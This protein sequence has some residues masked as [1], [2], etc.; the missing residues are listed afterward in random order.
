[1]SDATFAASFGLSPLGV[2]GRSTNTSGNV[3]LAGSAL[4]PTITAE[5]RSEFY[6]LLSTL[7]N[8]GCDISATYIME[9]F[10]TL[11][12]FDAILHSDERHLFVSTSQQLITKQLK[13]LQTVRHKVKLLE[14]NATFVEELI[15][16][17]AV[18]EV[19]CGSHKAEELDDAEDGGAATATTAPDMGT[20]VAEEDAEGGEVSN[21]VS[22]TNNNEDSGNAGGEPAGAVRSSPLQQQQQRVTSSHGMR[23]ALHRPHSGSL[24]N[25]VRSTTSSAHRRRCFSFDEDLDEIIHRSNDALAALQQQ[26]QQQQEQRQEQERRGG[27]EKRGTGGDINTFTVSSSTSPFRQRHLQR[28]PPLPLTLI[29]DITPTATA[30]GLAGGTPRTASHDQQG[31]QAA[32]SAAPTAEPLVERGSSD[33]ATGASPS[34]DDKEGGS[35]IGDNSATN[36]NAGVAPAVFA[37]VQHALQNHF[38]QNVKKTLTGT[39]WTAPTS[40][41]ETAPSRDPGA[42]ECSTSPPL[43]DVNVSDSDK[44]KTSVATAPPQ[45]QPSSSAC[46]PCRPFS[47]SQLSNTSNNKNNSLYPG[48]INA[49]S[50]N[51]V[52]DFSV[53]A[54]GG[55]GGGDPYA[56]LYFSTNLD[57]VDTARVWD[58]MFWGFLDGR[59]AT[60]DLVILLSLLNNANAALA[61]LQVSEMGGKHAGSEAAPAAISSTNTAKAA[62]KPVG[63]GIGSSNRLA[64]SSMD[65]VVKSPTAPVIPTPDCGALPLMEALKR[66]GSYAELLPP[67]VLGNMSFAS[68]V[69]AAAAAGVSLPAIA[70]TAAG[71]AGTTEDSAFPRIRRDRAGELTEDEEQARAV[72]CTTD[73]PAFFPGNSAVVNMRGGEG[74]NLTYTTSNLDNAALPPPPPQQTPRQWLNLEDYARAEEAR[75]HRDF[76]AHIPAV[77][78]TLSEGLMYGDSHRGSS[79]HA[80][81]QKDEKAGSDPSSSGARR[82]RQRSTSTA[83]AAAVAAEAGGEVAG[84]PANASFLVDTADQRGVHNGAEDR[85]PWGDVTPPHAEVGDDTGKEEDEEREEAAAES[86]VFVPLHLPSEEALQLLPTF[87]PLL[88]NY[89]GAVGKLFHVAPEYARSTQA[90]HARAL[91]NA[92]A[93][94]QQRHQV[95]QQLDTPGLIDINTVSGFTSES[96]LG[97]VSVAVSTATG[98]MVP[99]SGG[100]GTARKL[101]RAATHRSS[102]TNLPELHERAHRTYSTSGDRRG[103][104]PPPVSGRNRSGG[105]DASKS[106]QINALPTATAAST[107]ATS[108]ERTDLGLLGEGSCTEL[109][110]VDV[111]LYALVTAVYVQ[112]AMPIRYQQRRQMM[113]GGAKDGAG[114]GGRSTAVEH[115][116]ALEERA[117]PSEGGRSP[118]G[119]FSPQPGLGWPGGSAVTPS[120]MSFAGDGTVAAEDARAQNWSLANGS[121]SYAAAAGNVG[122]YPGGWWNGTDRGHLPSSFS[123]GRAPHILRPSQ[124]QQLSS[125]LRGGRYDNASFATL[126]QQQQYLP[127]FS[128]NLSGSPTEAALAFL[129]GAHDDRANGGNGA[130]VKNGED[131]DG[132]TTRGAPLSMSFST[133]DVLACAN[134]FSWVAL[135]NI[136]KVE[137][138]TLQAQ[139]Q[140]TRKAVQRIEAQVRGELALLLFR[141]LSMVLDWLMPAVYVADPRIWL[142]YRKWCCDLYRVLCTDLAL[143]DEFRKLLNQSGVA[144]I[145]ASPG[146]DTEANY[147]RGGRRE[148]GGASAKS[149][150]AT[151]TYKPARSEGNS[152]TPPR[153]APQPSSLGS[154]STGAPTVTLGA[155]EGRRTARTGSSP[156][157]EGNERG[158]TAAASPLS[159][160]APPRGS[161]GGSA[162]EAAHE[163]GSRRSSSNDNNEDPHHR[164]AAESDEADLYSFILPG[165][166][167][168]GSVL[169]TTPRVQPG[170]SNLLGQG[171]AD[172]RGEGLAD[173]ASL[174]AAQALL[175]DEDK[176]VPLPR[177]FLLTKLVAA[178]LRGIDA[179]VAESL[180]WVVGEATAASHGSAEDGE[181]ADVVWQR[182]TVD[183]IDGFAGSPTT[184]QRLDGVPSSSHGAA[185]DNV[186]STAQWKSQRPRHGSRTA[187]G[188]RMR[189]SQQGS[190]N[191]NSSNRNQNDSAD[192]NVLAISSRRNVS[193]TVRGNSSA[194]S[195]RAG[196]PHF[197]GD[198]VDDDD[199][200]DDSDSDDLPGLNRRFSRPRWYNDEASGRTRR[201]GARLPPAPVQSPVVA[202]PGGSSGAD[203]SMPAIG[204]VAGFPI[205]PL[206]ASYA[207]ADLSMSNSPQLPYSSLSQSLPSPS[208]VVAVAEGPMLV[209]HHRFRYPSVSGYA[210]VA[211][212]YLS[213]LEDAELLLSPHDPIYASLILST[214]DLHVHDLHDRETA[215]TLVNSY[216]ADVGEEQIQGPVWDILS[217]TLKP[218]DGTGSSSAAAG[219]GGSANATTSSAAA[220]PVPGR[221]FSVTRVRQGNTGTGSGW[222]LP[223]TNNASAPSA[224]AMNPPVPQQPYVPMVIASWNNEREK[225]EFL[226]TLRVLRQIQVFLTQW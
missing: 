149:A 27:D 209:H 51:Q 5:L 181:K 23:P 152:R 199:D 172:R 175:S 154:S 153:P 17:C 90:Q 133:Q 174:R 131:G 217:T 123:F 18:L 165:S 136:M 46:P 132:A 176:V 2:S 201:R 162:D 205:M 6:P 66:T 85:E 208:Q 53:D 83:T 62:T 184:V 100:D 50:V 168:V 215:A 141:V 121:F 72:S 82:G 145:A 138:Q 216:L 126:Q 38:R 63:H 166:S 179:D 57:P 12:R 81:Q 159:Q 221:G 55:G 31:S 144:V 161:G 173:T 108:P 191:N 212:L 36:I 103:A 155:G 178:T 189:T 56:S 20:G 156:A 86:E 183:G 150:T 196:S 13:Q 21:T 119:S 226:G 67:P 89:T 224:A 186:H 127:N 187:S 39:N 112:C 98:S 142:F 116:L 1:M 203:G 77:L 26:E 146:V 163:N 59:T 128:F 213:T 114:T 88:R 33:E 160:E 105:G 190:T 110:P 65:A 129:R 115:S 220:S 157:T 210:D 211:Q 42:S 101:T 74:S 135:P 37:G 158:R 47:A 124:Q 22:S 195:G 111:V 69:A 7:A 28:P 45:Q 193:A 218:I 52:N 92:A 49:A 91:A 94:Q 84:A 15:E 35:A 134:E 102:V 78:V 71:G 192:A 25:T 198:F 118:A 106:S 143:L 180:L 109:R 54:G 194:V 125:L 225:D 61:A 40:A 29:G 219:G 148:A 9:L 60:A 188:H 204:A 8:S 41:T 222:S 43:A 24:S 164:N 32:S 139:L 14:E 107:A 130:R 79:A 48:Q 73:A 200:D 120:G 4:L 182:A 206:H 44:E 137:L 169:F 10:F 113:H 223:P 3:G 202:G 16:R 177:P 58:R 97:E 185:A 117:S 11:V 93:Q 104:P 170:V 207:A 140:A 19:L 76:W 197:S 34:A 64:G 122:G 147:P 99:E 171:E 87:S 95:Q 214:A 96:E 167:L 75:L 70:G 30:A 80:Q 151:P 68:A